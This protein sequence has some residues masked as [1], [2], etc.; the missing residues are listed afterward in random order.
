MRASWGL[1]MMSRFSRAGLSV[2]CVVV[3]MVLTLECALA[4]PLEDAIAA[5]N[6]GDYATALL[7]FRPLGEQGSAKAQSN[8]VFNVRIEPRRSRQRCGGH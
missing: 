8:L 3:A 6:R 1:R 5:F 4:G 2:V 7:I